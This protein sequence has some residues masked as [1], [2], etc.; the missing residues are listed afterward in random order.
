MPLPFKPLADRV[1]LV[2]GASRGIGHATALRLA[3]LGAHVFAVARTMPDLHKLE[4]A[5]RAEGGSAACL[6]LDLGSEEAIAGLAS[7]VER[8]H[9]RL[10]ILFGNAGAPG[11]NISVEQVSVADWNAVFAVNLVAN[12][13][14][15]RYFDPLL[16]RS[17]APRAIFMSS[18]AVRQA[19]ARRGVYAAS[20]AA[21][22]S[23]IR[24]YAEANVDSPLRVNLF[25]PGPVRT[26]MRAT[27]APDE[28]PMELATPEECA[29]EIVSLLMPHVTVTGRF[30]DFPSH[31]FVPYPRPSKVPPDVRNRDW[32]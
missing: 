12:W 21:L 4:D 5:V 31:G 22:E 20:K 24:A 32:I 1:A 9:G 2:T 17:D 28:N 25:N 7:E 11:P 30:Y 14:L 16:K 13:H 18:S 23:L 26:Q 10:D 19:R 29:A 6:P 27:V 8:R 15:L 3:Q